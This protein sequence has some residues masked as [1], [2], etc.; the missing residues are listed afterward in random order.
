MSVLADL[1]KGRDTLN[2]PILLAKQDHYGISGLSLS[3]F[4]SYLTNRILRVKVGGTVSDSAVSNISVPRPNAALI[5]PSI[6]LN[7]LSKTS[8]ISL[9]I[10]QNKALRFMTNTGEKEFRTSQSLHHQ[11]N[12][13]P[14]NIVIHQQ[15]RALWQQF[16]QNLPRVFRQLIENRPQ[17]TINSRFPSSRLAAEQPD[18]LPINR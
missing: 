14:I 2:H 8:I 4:A 1:K 12:I 18:P 15:S 17:T 13:L 16:Q 11:M 3:R 5:Y 7:T 6:I 9:E 10:V